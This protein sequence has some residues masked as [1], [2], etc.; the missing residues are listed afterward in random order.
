MKNLSYIFSLAILIL[1]TCTGC[2]LYE[3]LKNNKKEVARQ[4]DKIKAAVNREDWSY[5]YQ[6]QDS[7]FRWQS[8]DNQIFETVEVKKGKATE[9]VELGK[10]NFRESIN[11]L[12]KNRVAFYIKVEEVRKIADDR[13]VARVK[14]R[15]KIRTG[16]ADTDNIYWDSQYTWVKRVEDWFLIEI[17]DLSI[18]KSALGNVYDTNP[19]PPPPPTKTTA[20]KTVPSATKTPQNTTKTK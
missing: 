19:T 9:K 15:L 14:S 1:T 6:F 2:N 20:V 3:M 10:I 17:K 5:I 8:S 7:N 4:I 13:Y 12:P 18:K 11:N 16:A